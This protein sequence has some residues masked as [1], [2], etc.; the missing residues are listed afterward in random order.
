MKKMNPA[1]ESLKLLQPDS[2]V[3]VGTFSGTLCR[4]LGV[5]YIVPPPRLLDA[6]LQIKSVFDPCSSLVE[7][8]TIANFIR[9]GQYRRHLRKMRGIYM[10][11]YRL[12]REL[13][14]KFLPGAFEWNNESLHL[15]GK[16]RLGAEEL[17]LFRDRC[18]RKGVRMPEVEGFYF[19]AFS[20]PVALFAFS[21]LSDVQLREGVRIMNGIYE[22][23]VL[24][25]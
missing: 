18:Y 22:Q 11:K 15:F 21:H 10:H 3:F 6:L 7:Q 23:I 14:D 9:K 17:R 24:G 19:G 8:Q 1:I 13:F 20:E 4:A 5:S 25:K 16:W 12:L 2:V